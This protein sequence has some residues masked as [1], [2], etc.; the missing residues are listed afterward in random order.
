MTLVRR[1]A[2]HAVLD[3]PRPI[4]SAGLRG[5]RHVSFLLNKHTPSCASLPICN[6]AVTLALSSPLQ[7]CAP[8]AALG[9][10]KIAR[11][12]CL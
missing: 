3:A 8:L 7:D 11:P 9:F 10:I 6:L 4:L 5:S 12:T 1:A 2:S